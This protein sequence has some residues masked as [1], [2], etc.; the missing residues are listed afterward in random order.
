MKKISDSTIRRLSKYYRSLEFLI[1]K[2][3]ETVSSDQLA[4]MDG[5]TS[6]QVRKDLSF[7]GTFG[8]RGLGYNCNILKN[9]IGEIL[10]LNREWNVVIVGAGNVGR[11]LADY[12]EFKKQGFR[13]SLILDS[14]PQ[15]VGAEIHGIIVKDFSKV[16][17]LVKANKID[18]AIIA[19]PVSAAQQ[20]A[21]VLV[22][23][24]VRAILN[25]APIS[26]K[27]SGNVQVK[28]ENMAIE[29]ESLSYYLTSKRN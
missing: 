10:G 13:I 24:G 21:D 17:D 11:A 12:A 23:S 15:K 19:V 22:D 2:K 5:I 9:Q 6:A 26:L 1:E 4:E 14:D 28:N 8:K 20:V 7:F 16:K 25:F 18:I 29:I 3:V 27:V